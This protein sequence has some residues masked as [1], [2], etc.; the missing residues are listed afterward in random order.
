MVE[1]HYFLPEAFP[2][3][4]PPSQATSFTPSSMFSKSLNSNTPMHLQAHT[5]PQNITDHISAILDLDE[6]YRLE[7]LE[8]LRVSPYVIL[9]LLSS[10]KADFQ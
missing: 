9:Q 6:I 7:F 5:D 10:D 1:P 2:L 8:F 3:T 4:F